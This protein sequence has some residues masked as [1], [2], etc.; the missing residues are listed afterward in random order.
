MLKL[1]QGIVFLFVC[2]FVVTFHQHL[3]LFLCQKNKYSRC[4]ENQL[5]V[6]YILCQSHKKKETD[7]HFHSCESG[8]FGWITCHGFVT[9]TLSLYTQI[10]QPIIGCVLSLLVIDHWQQSASL[11]NSCR[12]KWSNETLILGLT[13]SKS[14]L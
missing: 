3:H 9:V 4:E 1:R 5:P 12:L 10:M 13:N 6:E 2:L 11:Q 14:M 7:T 8:V